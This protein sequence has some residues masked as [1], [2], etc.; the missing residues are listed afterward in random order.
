MA[1]STAGLAFGGR[2]RL[3]ARRRLTS[4]V[5]SGPRCTR[6]RPSR[7][8]IRRTTITVRQFI[9]S[10]QRSNIVADG[11]RHLAPR[12]PQRPSA[13]PSASTTP[14]GTFPPP[15]HPIW[16]HR[17]PLTCLQLFHPFPN[18]PGLTSSS[19]PGASPGRPP[20]ARLT[21]AFPPCLPLLSQQLRGE[22]WRTHSHDR[23]RD[24]EPD[25]G[26]AR[27]AAG[28]HLLDRH[29]GHPGGHDARAQG[30]VGRQGSVLA[31]RP[32]GLGPREPRQPGQHGS[33]GRVH[34]RG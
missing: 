16:T 27:R 10:Q 14:P 31:G 11:V 5:C 25:Q 29:R 22:P 28:L 34:H 32:A 7:S 13:T 21:P 6:F 15:R 12:S 26:P 24:L 8:K 23:P 30:P 2:C 17:Q 9:H 18:F 1:D 4:S 3:R 33:R 19:T 20:R